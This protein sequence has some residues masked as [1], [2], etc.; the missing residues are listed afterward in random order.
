M[1][2][3]CKSPHQRLMPLALFVVLVFTSVLVSPTVQ[4]SMAETP[5]EAI[6]RIQ[7]GRHTPM[8][9]PTT[10]PAT[11]V[12]GKGMTIE[13]G[14]RH[15]LHVHFSGSMTR[16]V[17]VPAARSESVELAVGDYQVAAEVP[18][19]RIIP[20]YGR[21]AYQPFTHYWLTF[22]TRQ[23]G[24]PTSQAAAPV[25]GFSWEGLVFGATK[26]DDV[27]QRFGSPTS[28]SAGTNPLMLLYSS[29][30]TDEEYIRQGSTTGVPYSEL[31]FA[32]VNG[33]LAAVRHIF[34]KMAPVLK[35]IR[36]IAPFACQDDF[37][38][39]YGKPRISGRI[40]GTLFKGRPFETFTVS[41][42]VLFTV[43]Y[44]GPGMGID[45]PS[46][47]MLVMLDWYHVIENTTRVHWPD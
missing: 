34:P 1:V 23:V 39:K 11:G 19:S 22:Y 10:A 8:P 5:E 30:L 46:G 14:T 40:E 16:T 32:F 3:I 7:A 26:P 9:P 33:T 13:N 38:S 24:L 12:G 17:V 41:R 25:R 37:H 4:T 15:T 29:A 45:C 20:F 31:R 27:R 2:I 28:T 44:L 43:T 35:P 18:G 36:P 21:Q 42:D 47:S 6:K